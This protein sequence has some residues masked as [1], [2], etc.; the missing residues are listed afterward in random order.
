MHEYHLLEILSIGFAF[1]L[2]FGYFAKRIGLSPIVGYLA[3]GFLIGPQSPGFVADP[4]LAHNL[5]EAGVILLMFGVGLHFNT[6]D[7]MKVKGVAVPGAV[8]QSVS[9]AACGIAAAYFSVIL[10]E[11]GCCW[12][13]GWLWPV[14]L[15]CSVCFPIIMS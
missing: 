6:D 5:S 7:L 2:I 3:A 12:D 13:S 14:R 8:V 4:D 10:S 1:A 15:F 9:A 11:R